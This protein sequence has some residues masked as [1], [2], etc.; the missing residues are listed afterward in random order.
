MEFIDEKLIYSLLE[1]GTL[2]NKD[3]QK[4]ILIKAKERKGIVYRSFK[5]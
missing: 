5:Y 4:D 3:L 1:D 2:K